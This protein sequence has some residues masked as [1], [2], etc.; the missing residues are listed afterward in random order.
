MVETM[1]KNI[2]PQE[3]LDQIKFLVKSEPND[4]T[5]GIRVREFINNLEKDVTYATPFY[6]TIDD[7]EQELKN[8]INSYYGR[9]NK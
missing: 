7:S 8:L 4:Q 6:P 9:N 2:Y 5:L 3:L 1:T